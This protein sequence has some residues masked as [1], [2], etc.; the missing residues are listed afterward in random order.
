ML[1]LEKYGE[2]EEKEEILLLRCSSVH[3]PTSDIFKSQKN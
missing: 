3:R 2:T 1:T